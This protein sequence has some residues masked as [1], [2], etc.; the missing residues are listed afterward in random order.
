MSGESECEIYEMKLNEIKST[1]RHLG[2][3]MEHYPLVGISDQ[4]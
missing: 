3:K 2:A 4:F 1:H